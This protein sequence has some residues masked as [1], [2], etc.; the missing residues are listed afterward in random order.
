MPSIPRRAWNLAGALAAFVADGCKTVSEAEYRSRL[1]I[2]DGC[3]LRSGNWCSKCGCSLS[4]KAKGR[5]WQC[6]EGQ[7]GD[8][9]K[10]EHREEAST[11][12]VA[13]PDSPAGTTPTPESSGPVRTSG[14]EPLLTDH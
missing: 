6:P 13:R 7:W 11:P 12:T 3:D 5:A 9:G 2:C 14:D 8:P 10:Y 1:E 4:L